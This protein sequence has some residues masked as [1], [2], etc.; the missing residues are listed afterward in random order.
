MQCLK[1]GQIYLRIY[2]ENKSGKINLSPFVTHHTSFD[3]IS[4]TAVPLPAAAWLF[5]SALLGL[6]WARRSRLQ[7]Q[8]VLCA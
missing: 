6:G 1:R 3:T 8:E 5:G 2:G 4:L 7:Q